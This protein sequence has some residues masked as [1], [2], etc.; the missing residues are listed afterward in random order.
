MEEISRQLTTCKKRQ[1]K[2]FLYVIIPPVQVLHAESL[3]SI[4]LNHITNHIVPNVY[5]TVILSCL[6]ILGTM[7]TI[8]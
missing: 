4:G 3:G 2:K 5:G 6:Y 8:R 1:H 7:G